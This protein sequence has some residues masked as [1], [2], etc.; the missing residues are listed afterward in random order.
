MQCPEDG[1]WN[2]HVGDKGYGGGI[3]WKRTG[4]DGKLMAER[5]GYRDSGFEYDS[6]GNNAYSHLSRKE[7]AQ[8]CTV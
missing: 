7:Q 2:L 4:K 1:R 6:I 5:I 3:I 8:P